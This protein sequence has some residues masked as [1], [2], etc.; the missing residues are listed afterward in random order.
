MDIFHVPSFWLNYNSEN[1]IE[2]NES[3][4]TIPYIDDTVPLCTQ[5]HVVGKGIHKTISPRDDEADS[6]IDVS[7]EDILG[8]GGMGIVFRHLQT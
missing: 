5:P 1:E 3:E 4:I 2:M 8:K 6:D 7:D